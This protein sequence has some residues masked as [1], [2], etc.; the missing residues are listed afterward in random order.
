M[1]FVLIKFFKIN[2]VYH[3]GVYLTI[4]SSVVL[5]PFFTCLLHSSVV[6]SPFVT[7]LPLS[8]HS[9]PVRQQLFLALSDTELST[10]TTFSAEFFTSFGITR[11]SFTAFLQSL[12]PFGAQQDDLDCFLELNE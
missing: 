11:F 7:C 3:C 8:L 4:F 6:L 2:Q 5:S 1:K 9:S 12:S 10:A